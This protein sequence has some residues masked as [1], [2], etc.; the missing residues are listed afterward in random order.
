MTQPLTEVRTYRGYALDPFQQEAIE[1]I[2]RGDS[3]LVAA[4][5]GTGKTLI[6]DY[7][8][9]QTKPRWA[10]TERAPALSTLS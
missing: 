8:I 6:A 1:H 5:T 2:D 3:V 10:T 9:E 4:P 7:L